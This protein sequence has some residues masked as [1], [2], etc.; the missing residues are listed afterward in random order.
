MSF[1]PRP[2]TMGQA[3]HRSKLWD[4]SILSGMKL[5]FIP[6][7]SQT[8][9]SWSPLLLKAWKWELLKSYS[10]VD[11]ASAAHSWTEL[12]TAGS[13]I[14]LEPHKVK[15]ANTLSNP[16]CIA[17]ELCRNAVTAK[18]D[19]VK[20][21]IEVLCFIY[22]FYMKWKCNHLFPPSFFYIWVTHRKTVREVTSFNS[23]LSM[24]VKLFR[25]VSFWTWVMRKIER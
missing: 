22:V 24:F 25:N 11:G 12:S 14:W 17:L 16:I 3:Q 19:P 13:L 7:E 10:S 2:Q 20:A 18:I 1:P 15:R 4:K 5:S 23:F 6:G 9:T 21:E 8:N